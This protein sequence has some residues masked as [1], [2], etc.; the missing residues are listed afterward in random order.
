MTS[1]PPDS[2]PLSTSGNTRVSNDGNKKGQ[3]PSKAVGADSEAR[4]DIPDVF[5]MAPDPITALI[6]LVDAW[7]EIEQHLTADTIAS[8]SDFEKEVLDVIR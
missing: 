2:H 3:T 8:P 6:P 1:T 7:L 5:G 4:G